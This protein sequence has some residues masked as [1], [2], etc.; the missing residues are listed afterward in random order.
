MGGWGVKLSHPLFA[1]LP[2]SGATG[3]SLKKSASTLEARGHFTYRKL[4]VLTALIEYMFTCGLFLVHACLVP[5]S[6]L[7]CSLFM[8]VLFLVHA[9]LACLAFSKIDTLQGH[10]S[11]CA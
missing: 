2:Y 1:M 4:F 10:C 7:S 5:C 6:C 9:C 11:V 3:Y 8:L